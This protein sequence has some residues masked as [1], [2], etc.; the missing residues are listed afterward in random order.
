MWRVRSVWRTKPKARRELQVQ[1]ESERE[2]QALQVSRVLCW[3]RRLGLWAAIGVSEGFSAGLSE[4]HLRNHAD[5]EAF[6]LNAVR[7]DSVGILQ[8][9][10]CIQHQRPQ[11]KCHYAFAQQQEQAHQSRS[12]SAEEPPNPYPPES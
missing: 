3:S 4:A 1:Q 8:N 2:R 12:A 5:D 9:L 7:L 10:A 6:L 11:P